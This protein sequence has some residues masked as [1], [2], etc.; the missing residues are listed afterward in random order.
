MTEP[1]A[2]IGIMDRPHIPRAGDPDLHRHKEWW[3]FNVIDDRSGLDLIVNL[4]I[5]G[6]VRTPAGGEANLV[7]LAYDQRIGWTGNIDQYDGLAARIDPRRLEISVGASTIAYKEGAFRLNL[8]SRDGLVASLI[9]FP[10]TEPL[11][12]WK[13]TRLGSGHINWVIVPSLRAEGTLVVGDR[14]HRISEARAYHD[15]NWGE[16]R[17]GEN[18]GWDWGFCSAALMA[19]GQPISFVYDR[20]SDRTGSRTLEHS[21]MLWRGREL[22]KFFTRRMLRVR[23]SGW[24]RG[25]I[26]RLPGVAHL[27]DARS[28]ATIPARLEIAVDD[29]SDRLEA[30]YIPD[31]AVQI[32]LARETGD[33][34]LALNETMGW[35]T[36]SARIDGVAM[37]VTRRACFEFV[38]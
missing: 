32:A 7:V 27:V 15:H 16:W 14:V 11:V 24:F 36:L 3:H 10:E 9:L 23:R 22:T 31:T 19:D 28:V 6:D 20:T 5:S 37:T 35:L 34:L 4:S 26:R 13:D 21:L 18:F 17:W 1:R 38:A 25:P 8:A 29:S 33:G 30:T 12:V 2:E